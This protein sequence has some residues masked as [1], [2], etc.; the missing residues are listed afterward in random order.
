MEDQYGSHEELAV[1]AN[2]CVTVDLLLL[3]ELDKLLVLLL[4][5]D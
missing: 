1:Y 2:A 4:P 5:M 3:I